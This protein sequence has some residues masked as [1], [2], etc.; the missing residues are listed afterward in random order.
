M[1]VYDNV[2]RTAPAVADID[3]DKQMEILVSS[4]DYGG[5]IAYDVIGAAQPAQ[6]TQPTGAQAIPTNDKLTV[7]GQAVAPTAYKI[8][9]ENYFKLRDVAMLLKDSGSQF[10][11]DYDGAV[12]V[13]T[14][15][16]YESVG[17][18][19]AGVPTANAQALPSNDALYVNGTQRQLTAYKINNENYFRLRDLGD[20][21]GFQVGYDGATR[22]A[23]ITTK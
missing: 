14:G 11:V 4:S 15:Q 8:N 18:E 6:P 7:D 19:L 16:P 17:G 22:T 23:T 21:L 10:S 2:S 20:A 9:N 12:Q 13:V 5:L 3:G 1:I